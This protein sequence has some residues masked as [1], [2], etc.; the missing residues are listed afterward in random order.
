MPHL[1]EARMIVEG[2]T[3]LLAPVLMFCWTVTSC[4][5]SHRECGLREWSGMCTQR[6]VVKIQ[7]IEF[8]VPTS[9]FEVVYTPQP[10]PESPNLTPPE[11]RI[12]YRVRS[13]H[14]SMLRNHLDANRS[15]RC[16]MPTPPAGTCTAEPVVAD[17]PPFDP[18]R[19]ASP[20]QQGPTACAKIE[21]AQGDQSG[22][23]HS[24][25]AI[26]SRE[27][28][29][30]EVNDSRPSLAATAVADQVA[31]QL[32]ADPTLECV[33][34]VG[35][36]TAGETHAL[37]GERARA[38]RQLLIERGVDANRL[39]TLSGTISTLGVGTA[40]MADPSERRVIVRVVL[41]TKSS[42]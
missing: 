17:L 13:S 38:I 39:I 16:H 5:P 6:S 26:L 15:A 36:V 8:P 37:A 14:E 18:A 27:P 34:L 2:R 10:N 21:A 4:G 12:E 23:S 3:S 9:V 1:R 24:S 33:A 11:M 42:R 40:R 25:Q 30:F 19:A 20:V 28:M 32:R 22:E 31:A 41:R 35:G 7:E 29:L